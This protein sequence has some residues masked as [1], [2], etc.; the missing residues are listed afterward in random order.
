VTVLFLAFLR[1]PFAV[2]WN[3]LLM[4]AQERWAVQLE[5]TT[6]WSRVAASRCSSVFALLHISQVTYSL[7]Y[8]Q[9]SIW[10]V[11]WGNTS[12]SM[13]PVKC[14]KVQ[15]RNYTV[16][17]QH[18]FK[19]SYA[20]IVPPSVPAQPLRADSTP[21]RRVNEGKLRIK[22]SHKSRVKIFFVALPWNHR[23]R[24][25]P[26]VA[27]ACVCVCVLLHIIVCM[28]HESTFFRFLLFWM[29]PNTTSFH[30]AV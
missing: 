2:A 25:G 24:N 9:I 19:W 16:T 15:I 23:Q 28:C 4:A 26:V 18:G 6:I 1:S 13:S 14:A 27:G 10:K 7:M 5:H 20:P 11:Y 22:Q 12:K 30:S 8:F 29:Y 21:P 3:P 17:Q